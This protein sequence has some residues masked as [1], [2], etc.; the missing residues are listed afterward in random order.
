[1]QEQRWQAQ[2]Y[3]GNLYRR[4]KAR[5]DSPKAITAKA[6]K[7]ARVLW[8]LLKYK[9]TLQPGGLRQKGAKNETQEAGPSA[10]LC[11][12]SQISPRSKPM[13]CMSSFSGG[14]RLTPLNHLTWPPLLR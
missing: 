4:W 11:H 10:K 3:F 1:M 9:T 14:D 12:H 2:N 8:H 13:T 5:L 7:L 6:H